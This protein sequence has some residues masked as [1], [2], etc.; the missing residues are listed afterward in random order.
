MTDLSDDQFGG[1]LS[2]LASALSDQT[3][4]VQGFV[5]DLQAR[6]DAALQQHGPGVTAKTLVA[7]LVGILSYFETRLNALEEGD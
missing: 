5:R 6:H 1:F 2:T 3:P 7:D 4:A